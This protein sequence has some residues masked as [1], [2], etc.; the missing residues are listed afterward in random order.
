MLLV[1]H[2]GAIDRYEQH[3]QM[4]K[5]ILNNDINTHEQQVQGAMDGH[6]K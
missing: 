2:Q 1:I 3:E 6:V 4:G 5:N